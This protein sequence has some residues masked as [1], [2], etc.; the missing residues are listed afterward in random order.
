MQ[1][2]TLAPGYEISRVIRGGWQLAGGHGAVDPAVAVEDMVAFADAG[3]TTFDCADIYTGVEELIGRFRLAYRDLRGEEALRRIRVHTKFVPDLTVLPTI[4]K[5]YVEGV[6]DTSLKRLNLE[7]LDLVQFHWW[8]YDIDGWLETAGWLKELQQAGKIDKV[9]GTN[10]DSDHIE[11]L[12]AAGIPLASLQLQYSLLD[13]RPEKRMVSLA[14]QHGFALF[15]YGTVAGGFLSDKWLGVAEPAHPLENRS[16]TKYKLI[17]DDI[18]GWDLFQALLAT[19]RRIADR[20]R[21]DIATIASAAMLRRPGVAAVIVGARNRDHLAENL[22][23][24]DITLSDKDL[25]D[26]EAVMAEAKELEGDVYTLE[27]DRNGRHGSI[28]KY[29]LNKG[30]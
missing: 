20:H 12:L 5:A 16:L 23:I 17:I 1:R 7:R 10:F 18:G 15:C 8:A 4:S 27:R 9:S 21:T 6:I 11:A 26:I 25:S 13:R 3:I 29:N 19:L 22:A 14:A 2:I 24:S 30:E 28:M